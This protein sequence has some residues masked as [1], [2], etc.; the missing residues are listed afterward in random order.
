MLSPVLNPSYGSYQI[1]P[2]VDSAPGAL[3]TSF[4][5]GSVREP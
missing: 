4:L 3:A 2:G 1:F 5:N